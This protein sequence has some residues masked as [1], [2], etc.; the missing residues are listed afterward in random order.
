MNKPEDDTAEPGKRRYI[1]VLPMP[2]EDSLQNAKR[3][4]ARFIRDKRLSAK[5]DELLPLDEE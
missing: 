2:R 1:P 3:A 5:L 4:N